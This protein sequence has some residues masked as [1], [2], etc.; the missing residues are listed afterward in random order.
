MTRTMYAIPIALT[1]TEI[2]ATRSALLAVYDRQM[3]DVNPAVTSMLDKLKRATE[4]VNLMPDVVRL[5]DLP[6]EDIGQPFLVEVQ[7]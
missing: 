2:V 1:A 6:A 5:T 3:G 4:S 7:A